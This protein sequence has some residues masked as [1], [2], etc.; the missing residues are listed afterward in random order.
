MARV[1]V[2][3]GQDGVLTN[4]KVT[5]GIVILPFY[6]GFIFWNNTYENCR[7]LLE[8]PNILLWIWIFYEKQK[9]Y[10]KFWVRVL[11]KNMV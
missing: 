5:L 11:F 8:V 10:Q 4:G 9:Q 3:N 1:H 7:S 2:F 6:E